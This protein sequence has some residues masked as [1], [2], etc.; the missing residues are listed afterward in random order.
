MLRG[1]QDD[2]IA[3]KQQGTREEP[4]ASQKIDV[5]LAKEDILLMWRF[6]KF[7]DS[8]LGGWLS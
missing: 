6:L 1:M 8:L 5:W 7:K 3:C 4:T 2:G